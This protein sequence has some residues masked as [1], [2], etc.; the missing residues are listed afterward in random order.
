M[1]I[2]FR[3][4]RTQLISVTVVLLAA[5]ST[6]AAAPAWAAPTALS[7]A[8]TVAGCGKA[9]TV[10]TPTSAAYT[11][12]AS[13]AGALNLRASDPLVGIALTDVSSSG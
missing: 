5:G 13:L 9:M 10:H 12:A 4:L 1:N 6:I 11:S 2:R 8:R 7:T 3:H